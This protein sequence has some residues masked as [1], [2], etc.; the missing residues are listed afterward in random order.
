MVRQ[1]GISATSTEDESETQELRI[2]DPG[3]QTTRLM[4]GELLNL[5]AATDYYPVAIGRSEAIAT[6]EVRG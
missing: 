1:L 6:S 2:L 3:D 5:R 4:S